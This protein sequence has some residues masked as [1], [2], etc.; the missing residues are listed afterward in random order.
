MFSSD[1][2]NSF[3]KDGKLEIKPTLLTDREV[4]EGTISLNRYVE[5][6]LTSHLILLYL[7]LQT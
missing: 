4:Q 1:P 6:Y 3:Q 2:R 7:H 5:T